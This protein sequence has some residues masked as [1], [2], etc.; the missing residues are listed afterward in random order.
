MVGLTGTTA[1]I[2]SGHSGIDDGEAYLI[3]VSGTTPQV[4]DTLRLINGSLIIT[5]IGIAKISST[6]IIVSYTDTFSN[7]NCEAVIV[8]ESSGTLSK[9]TNVEFSTSVAE[10]QSI[11][12]PD[13]THAVMTVGVNNVEIQTTVMEI[14]GTSLTALTTFQ[15]VSGDKEFVTNG[16]VGQKWVV[17][18]YKDENDASKGKVLVLGV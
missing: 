7:K 10:E 3:S 11:A 18:A 8:T 15:N 5:D 14:D 6:Q 9:G 1:I 13:V 12:L 16:Q 2:V 17:S 4:D